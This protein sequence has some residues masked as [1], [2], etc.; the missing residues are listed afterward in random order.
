MAETS[1][2]EQGWHIVLERENWP[3][4]P[5]RKKLTLEQFAD[6]F[7]WGT[8]YDEE[9]LAWKKAPHHALRLRADATLPE[10]TDP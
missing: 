8:D 1:I 5:Q 2:T 6:L 10:S 4:G 9:S 7:E 3:H